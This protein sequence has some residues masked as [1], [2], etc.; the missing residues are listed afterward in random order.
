VHGDAFWEPAPE[1]R[2]HQSRF[3]PRVG[4]FAPA[5]EPVHASRRIMVDTTFAADIHCSSVTCGRMVTV[6]LLSHSSL[7]PRRFEFHAEWLRDEPCDATTTGQNT[8]PV[9]TLSWMVARG[10][11]GNMRF[12]HGSSPLHP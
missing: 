7:R 8:V 6:L 3:L 2:T 5:I 1:P 4:I 12:G 11:A 9:S 10:R